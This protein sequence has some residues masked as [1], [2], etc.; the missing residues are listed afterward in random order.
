M[1]RESDNLQALG[2]ATKYRDDY[3]PEV[4]ES[5]EN[6]HPG[7]DTGYV[8]KKL[9]FCDVWDWD[10]FGRLEYPVFFDYP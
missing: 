4:L 1:N 9:Y 7:N 3:A 8:G 2:K 10:T 5:F 6:K